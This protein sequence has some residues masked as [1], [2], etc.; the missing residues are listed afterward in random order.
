MAAN[1]HSD[2]AITAIE[3][4]VDANVWKVQVE[5][6]DSVKPK[7]VIAILGMFTQTSA[8]KQCN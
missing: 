4:P 3:A 5:E 2:P 7:Q 6:G 8:Y 1:T